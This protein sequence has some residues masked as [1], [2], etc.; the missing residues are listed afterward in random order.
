MRAA[1]E[2]IQEL[3]EQDPMGCRAYVELCSQLILRY[4]SSVSDQIVGKDMDG[5]SILMHI[6][7]VMYCNSIC[8]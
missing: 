3:F 5:H 2:E 8:S 7:I 4:V 6:A 1:V